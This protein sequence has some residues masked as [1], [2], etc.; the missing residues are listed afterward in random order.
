[1]SR[2]IFNRV[3][4]RKIKRSPFELSHKILTTMEMGKLYPVGSPIMCIPGDKIKLGHQIVAHANPMGAPAFADMSI[5]FM[6]FFVAFRNLYDNDKLFERFIANEKLD[7]GDTPVLPRMNVT[8]HSELNN[9]NY[10]V[11]NTLWD[12]FGFQT[13]CKPAGSSA[14]LDAPFRAYLQIWN[15]YFRDE[16]LQD[17]LD[18]NDM[19]NTLAPQY[20]NYGRDYLTSAFTSPQQGDAVALPLT[21]YAPIRG[22]YSVYSSVYPGSTDLGTFRIGSASN[23]SNPDTNLIVQSEQFTGNISE[24]HNAMIHNA[25]SAQLGYDFIDDPT[26]PM[27]NNDPLYADL[28]QASSYDINDLRLANANQRWKEINNLCGT[29]YTEF[30]RAQYGVAPR[31]ERLQRPEYIGGTK[32]PIIVSQVL[33]TSNSTNEVSPTGTKYGQGMIVNTDYSG[34][35]HVKEHGMIITLAFIR[36][37]TLYQDGIPREWTPETY[38]DFMNPLFVGLGE[39]GI[40]NSEVFCQDDETVNN[41]IWGYES[42][43]QEYRYRPDRV[44]GK[45][46]TNVTGN[47]NNSFD[48]WHLGRHFSSLPQL[49]N[50]FI[51]CNPSTR[52]FQAGDTEV[53]YL[54]EIG[55]IIKAVRPLPYYAVPHL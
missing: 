30:L 3:P 7:N 36:P 45:M 37:K 29:R 48:Y 49:N 11:Y 41:T 23:I 43:Y 35:Y 51:K 38:L 21:G 33:Q 47:M 19:T 5:Y 26:N 20:V 16:K 15:E 2:N 34:T 32:A 40:K 53:Q 22:D 27:G 25:D 46:R 13:G 24:S 42:M 55:Q 14:P 18:I 28:S 6:D 1:M 9:Q 39:Q 12:Y 10:T 31:D 4:V 17:E 44:T 52:I 8:D 54:C 50:E